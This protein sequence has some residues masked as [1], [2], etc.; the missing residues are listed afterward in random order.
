MADRTYLC[1]LPAMFKKRTCAS[2]LVDSLGYDCAAQMSRSV[3]SD[4]K[5]VLALASAGGK[6]EDTR[7]ETSV[8]KHTSMPATWVG[9]LRKR[10][11]HQ[12]GGTE[13]LADMHVLL[14]CRGAR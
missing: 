6:H 2:V 3:V 4:A 11:S 1:S 13:R 8:I 10:P 9:A 5:L 12:A 14:T 7:E